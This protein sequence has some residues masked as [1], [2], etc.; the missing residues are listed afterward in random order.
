MIQTIKSQE[1]YRNFFKR[2]LYLDK[3]ILGYPRGDG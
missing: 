1:E 2:K 3:Y